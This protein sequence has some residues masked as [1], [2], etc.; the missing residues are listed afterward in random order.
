MPTSSQYPSVLGQ[1][2]IYGLDGRITGWKV[3]PGQEASGWDYRTNSFSNP[4]GG[5]TAGNPA[6]GV[7]SYFNGAAGGLGSSYGGVPSTVG[8]GTSGGGTTAFSLNPTPTEGGGTT[9]G[10]VPGALGAPPSIWEQEQ[11]IPGMDAATKANMGNINAELAGQLSPGT[12]ENLINSAAARG[13]TLGQGG[14]TGL[15]NEALLKTLGLTQEELKAAGATHYNQFLSTSGSQQ[16]NPALLAEIADS[17]AKNAAAPNPTLAAEEA[18]ALG[19]GNGIG[20]SSS[21]PSSAT[22]RNFGGDGGNYNATSS[23]GDGAYAALLQQYLAAMNPNNSS[24]IYQ[25]YP[26]QNYSEPAQ[27]TWDYSGYNDFWNS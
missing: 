19:R 7:G 10:Q 16:Q 25:N 13:L 6:S 4:A 20:S 11:D 5:N 15:V 2:P 23:G 8:T 17:N 18:I 1:A 24:Q 22:Q 27:D 3:D 14:N 12:T 21:R 26:T 9:F